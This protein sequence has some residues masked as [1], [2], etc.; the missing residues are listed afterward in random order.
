MFKNTK[1]NRELL[2]RKGF[3]APPSVE[4]DPLKIATSIGKTIEAWNEEHGYEGPLLVVDVREF[5]NALRDND[6]EGKE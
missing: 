2:K 4:S 1:E 6:L 5:N 3:T